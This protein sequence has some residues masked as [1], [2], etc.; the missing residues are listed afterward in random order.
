MGKSNCVVQKSIAV[1][2]SST[3]KTVSTSTMY[4]RRPS[5]TGGNGLLLLAAVHRERN[6]LVDFH[7]R[8]LF[9]VESRCKSP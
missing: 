9:R 1:R 5:G 7:D 6:R 2:W 4:P 8:P 3:S